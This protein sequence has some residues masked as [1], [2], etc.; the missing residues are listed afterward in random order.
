MVQFGKKNAISDSKGEKKN[1]TFATFHL[2]NN[3]A[4]TT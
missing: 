4:K 3:D 1:L 2:E